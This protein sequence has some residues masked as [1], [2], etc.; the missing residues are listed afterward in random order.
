[1]LSADNLN[2]YKFEFDKNA[3]ANETAEQHSNRPLQTLKKLN[4]LYKKD[5]IQ[6]FQP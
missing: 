5:L 4:P 6:K 3:M 1:M 2:M